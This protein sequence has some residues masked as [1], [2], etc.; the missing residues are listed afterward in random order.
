MAEHLVDLSGVPL[1]EGDILFVNDDVNETV[2]TFKIENVTAR[3]EA[4]RVIRVRTIKSGN[5][6]VNSYHDL[7]LNAAVPTFG[8]IRKKSDVK[9]HDFEP[10]EFENFVINELRVYLDTKPKLQDAIKNIVT[11]MQLNKV[12]TGESYDEDKAALL[13]VAHSRKD[14]FTSKGGWIKSNGVPYD[15]PPTSFLPGMVNAAKELDY[16]K[17]QMACRLLIECGIFGDFK[18]KNG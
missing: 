15:S 4:N 9:K 18:F 12:L 16:A 13:R 10:L 6:E 7:V 1:E 8:R 5:L 11:Y 17:F 2:H 3:D 14:L